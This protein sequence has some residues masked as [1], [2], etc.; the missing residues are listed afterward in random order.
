MTPRLQGPGDHAA[1]ASPWVRRW[2]PPAPANGRAL[3]LAAG[4]GRHACF[5]AAAGYAVWAVDRDVSR[6]ADLPGV[7]PVARD[8]EGG[9]D[10]FADPPLVA[11]FEL[12]IVTNY[13][14]RPL[15]RGIA[16]AL[17]P[18]GRLIY[19]TF[20]RGHERHGRPS[21]ADFL[22]EPGELLRFADFGLQILGYEAG[23]TDAPAC[24]QRLCA[25][26]PAA[27]AAPAGPPLIPPP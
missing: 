26:R 25:W 18:G 1:A 14:H 7:A 22:L 12:I 6:L 4:G 3:D 13:L 24:V 27:H 23:E 9:D 21:R 17:K 16:A 20:M 11:A 2:T 5:A 8:L 10:P 19:E 15:F